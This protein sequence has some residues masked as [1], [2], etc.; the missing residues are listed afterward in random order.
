MNRLKL[1][2]CLLPLL[3]AGLLHAG[4]ELIVSAEPGNDLLRVLADS[5]YECVRVE[6]PAAAVGQAPEGGAVMILATGYPNTATPVDAALFAT[7]ASKNLRVYVEYPSSLP[8]LTVGARV[9]PTYDRAVVSSG[10]FGAGLA[11]LRIL[12]IHGLNYL[13]VNAT[14][15]HL[16][17]A[18]VAGFDTAVFGLDNTPTA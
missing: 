18:R 4:P 17:S 10:F 6:S 1:P 12:A 2:L 7:A 8:G 16:V 9:T 13:P 15:A 11:P 5:G 3:S 14:G